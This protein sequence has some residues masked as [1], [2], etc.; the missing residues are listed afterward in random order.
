MEIILLIMIPLSAGLLIQ[1]IGN[2]PDRIYR[3]ILALSGAFVMGMCFLHLLPETYLALN[4]LNDVGAILTGGAV[5]LGILFQIGLEWLTGGIEH[6]H[7]HIHSSKK[8]TV[9]KG[10]V[11]GLCIHA[12]I[13]GLPLSSAHAH[14][15]HFLVSILVHKFPVA[16]ILVMVLQSLGVSKLRSWLYLFLFACM[17]PLGILVSTFLANLISSIEVGM[18]LISGLV[19]GVLLHIGTTILFESNE[20]HTYNTSKFGVILLGFILAAIASV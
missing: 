11:F 1:I 12:F 15:H 18:L 3:L 10:L 2:I 8:G 19:I 4:S 14:E 5:I 13:E 9:P 17:A 16:L 20:D 7:T 6:G